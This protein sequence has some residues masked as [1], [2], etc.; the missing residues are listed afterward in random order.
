MVIFPSSTSKVVE[1]SIGDY[2][3]YDDDDDNDDYFLLIF[4]VHSF[5]LRFYF[6]TKKYKAKWKTKEHHKQQ[7]KRIF[8]DFF[9]YEKSE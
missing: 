5:F 4:N 2:D 7:T 9:S 8:S 3:D 6:C 1:S